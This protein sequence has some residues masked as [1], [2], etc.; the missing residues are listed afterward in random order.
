MLF[1][2]II[3]MFPHFHPV[4]EELALARIDGHRLQ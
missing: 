4:T 1:C 3:L 2:E